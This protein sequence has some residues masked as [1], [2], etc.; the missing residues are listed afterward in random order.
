[1]I[2]L[3]PSP[4]ASSQRPM[5]TAARVIIDRKST[6]LNSSHI[7]NSYAVTLIVHSFPTRRSSD[8]VDLLPGDVVV[9]ASDGILES[10]NATEEEFGLQ[11][12]SSVLSA[13]SPDDSARAIAERI[14]AETDDHSGAGDHRSEEHTSELQSHHELVCRH[15]HCPLFPYTTLFRSR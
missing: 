7:T 13:I 11:R 6:R 2:R 1:M 10:Q 15:S 8:L 12:L 4:N 3:A 14:L 9:F 5:I